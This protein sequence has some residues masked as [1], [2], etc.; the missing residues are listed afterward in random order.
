MATLKRRIARLENEFR[1]Q[2]WFHF[3]R[4]LE[5]LTDEQVEAIA[6]DWRFPEPLPEPLPRGMSELDRLDKKTLLKR[7]EEDERETSRIMREMAEHSEDERKF[8]VRHGHWPEQ[9]CGPECWLLR[10]SVTP[11]S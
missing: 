2:R 10:K 1:F 4:F 8:D 7:F 5:G 3:S 9:G 6:L 11:R